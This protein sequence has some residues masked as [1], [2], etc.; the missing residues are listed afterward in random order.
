MCLFGHMSCTNSFLSIFINNSAS[1]QRGGV[2]DRS[3]GETA[4][5][6]ASMPGRGQRRNQEPASSCGLATEPGGLGG[7]V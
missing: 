5:L 7:P 3:C 4:A 2:G 6:Q 1:G